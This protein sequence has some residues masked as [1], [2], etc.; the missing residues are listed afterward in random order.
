MP[1]VTILPCSLRGT[2]TYNRTID[3]RPKPSGSGLLQRVPREVKLLRTRSRSSFQ[4]GHRGP[5]SPAPTRNHRVSHA[6]PFTR[7]DPCDSRVRCSPPWVR[8]TLTPCSPFST[9]K[10]DHAE[11]VRSRNTAESRGCMTQRL[12]DRHRSQTHTL[13]NSRPWPLQSYSVNRPRS[14]L[15][16]SVLPVAKSLRPHTLCS[17]MCAP[18]D[19]TELSRTANAAAYVAPLITPSYP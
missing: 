2:R 13:L 3:L 7:A 8:S 6:S 14:R 11:G 5:L 10:L 16:T 1:T 18:Y 12:P 9:S 15:L 4:T 17:P 19:A